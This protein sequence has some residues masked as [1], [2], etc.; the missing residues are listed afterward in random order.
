MVSTLAQIESTGRISRLIFVGGLWPVF[1]GVVAATGLLAVLW[2]VVVDGVVRRR[3]SLS[4]VLKASAWLW[5]G[6]IAAGLAVSKT[7]PGPAGLLVMGGAIA[8]LL[9]YLYTLERQHVG[10]TTGLALTGLRIALVLLLLA[11]T[12][13]PVVR[14]NRTERQER[15]LAVLADESISMEVCDRHSTPG[16]RLAVADALGMLS[17]AAR[18][19]RLGPFAARLKACAASMDHVRATLAEVSRMGQAEGNRATVPEA[20]LRMLSDSVSKAR[21]VV[22]EMLESLDAAR[23]G[24]P[25]LP[26]DAEGALV[27][28]RS[29]LQTQ[30]RSGL[31]TLERVLSGLSAP[32]L[33]ASRRAERAAATVEQVRRGL[34]TTIEAMGALARELDKEFAR[35]ADAETRRAMERVGEMSRREV[36]A[37]LLARGEDGPLGSLAEKMDVRSFAFAGAVQEVAADQVRQRLLGEA[38]GFPSATTRPSPAGRGTGPVGVASQPKRPAPTQ[39]RDEARSATDL[40]GALR[41]VIEELGSDRFA[42]A[43]VLSDGRQNAQGDPV[44]VAQAYGG[45]GASVYPLTIGGRRPPTDAAVVALDVPEVVHVDDTI[46][47]SVSIRADGLSGRTLQIRLLDDSGQAVAL[48][49]EDELG[50][51]VVAQE[52][53]TAKTIALDSDR[54]RREVRMSHTPRGQGRHVYRVVIAPLAEEVFT[55]N[56]ER[57]FAVDVG[58]EKTK[59]LLVDGL[60]RWEFRY[61]RNLLLRDDAVRLQHVLFDPALVARQPEL[62]QVTAR[63]TNKTPEADRLPDEAG[64]LN[65][66]D[67]IILGDLSP[68]DLPIDKQ[69]MI[70]AFVSDRGGSLVVVAGKRH[71]PNRFLGQPLAG[72][73]PVR[74]RADDGEH[75]PRTSQAHAL[76]GAF[77][78]AFHLRLT[79]T[80]RNHIV[81]EFSVEHETNLELWSDFP[82]MHWRSTWS[83]AKEAAHVL[84]YADTV[85][86]PV[87][88]EL[89]EAPGGGALVER[90][91]PE[92][93]HAMLVAHQYGLGRVLYLGWD[94]TWRFRY[95]HGD[96]YHH[97]FWAQVLRWSTSGKLPTGMKLVKIGTDRARYAEGEP[98]TIRTKFTRP[99]YTPMTDASVRT[100]IRR[101]D[102]TVSSSRMRFVP[103]SP[104]MYET[105]VEGLE[106][107]Q[108]AVCVESPQIAELRQPDEPNEAVETMV[109]VEP[110]VT[111]ERLE[112][113]SDAALMSRLAEVSGGVELPLAPGSVLERL[114]DAEPKVRRR[115]E[116]VTLWD[117]W[118]F[119]L[120]FAAVIGAEWILRKRAGLM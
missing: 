58:D 104:G 111:A 5:I 102:Q 37:R 84:A 60:P 8:G 59:V 68:E 44:E 96:K 115:T 42:G 110:S 56:N 90:K 93:E 85:V 2:L 3:F 103:D 46:D 72:L 101:G 23:E 32:S 22:D 112:L 17:E 92:R 120:A 71:M 4:L 34:A 95:K 1:W 119:L 12:A 73:L 113:A 33:E 107:G 116:Q 105:T 65:A 31:E 52:P 45:S 15:V 18:P 76:T 53:K 86:S 117:T 55:E 78:D 41:K 88:K 19:I 26:R 98:I 94:A 35:T 69:R 83:H 91:A 9:I 6:V 106:P 74:C 48:R 51:E 7:D 89:Q 109:V 30:V 29:R 64:D 47:L 28:I 49:E 108:Y 97:K 99:D 27:D 81:T 75:P 39:G 67:V 77:E 24:Q 54:V 82:A 25:T 61:L 79:G 38:S 66:F 114:V 21:A 13:E 14:L 80:G 87:P 63:V 20:R 62:Q 57:V 40:A 50:R 11:M 70:E 36:A 118:W 43:V 100:V 16:E 10:R